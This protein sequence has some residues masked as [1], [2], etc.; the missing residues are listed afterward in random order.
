MLKKITKD[1]KGIT[2]I[3][4]ILTIIIMLILVSVTTYTGIDTYKES[5]VTAFVSQMQLIQ[6]KVDNIK[7]EK[8][9]DE[10]MLFGEDANSSNQISSI[11][12]AF[13]NSEIT[14]NDINSYR[15]FTKSK[16]LE[17][18]DIEEAYDDVMIN[19]TTREVVS[20]NGVEYKGTKYYTQYKL[21]N[22][23]SIVNS[24]V[25]VPREL[26]FNLETS[27]DG[28]NCSLTIN[29]ISITNGTL[30]FAETD[31][32]GNKSN[33]QMVTNYTEKDNEYTANISKSGNYT[34]RLQDNTSKDNYLEK[35]IVITLTN[36]PKTNLILE[37]YDYGVDSSLWAYTQKDSINYVW[38]PRFVYKTNTDANNTSIKFIKGN[39]NISTD[40]T[41]IN[42]DWMLHDKFTA[43]NGTELTGVWINVDSLNQAG[44]NMIDLLNDNTRTILT[45]I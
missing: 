31:L 22:G 5:K 33:W 9:I 41:Y 17:I 30:S 37:F 6:S 3:A 45:E 13:S 39:S 36:R 35:T 18:F 11:N 26:A 40:N 29:H 19:F 12:S 14:S 2:L 25:Y 15:Y 44:L 8:T 32:E 7:N 43:D 24:E 23:Q 20:L 34:F 21:P 16:L 4:L 1:N 27:I 10:L 28:L 42:N 38:I